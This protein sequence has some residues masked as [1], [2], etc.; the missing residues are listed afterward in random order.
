MNSA[1]VGKAVDAYPLKKTPEIES[2]I[3]KLMK[4]DTGGDPTTG[5]KW[6]RKTRQKMVD[7]LR[8]S[9][10]IVIGKTKLGEFLH[11]L[12]YSLKG[13]RKNLSMGS[14]PDRNQQFQMIAKRRGEFEAAGNPIISVDAKKR[15]LVGRFYNRGAA[16]RKEP[17]NVN[18]H[19]FPSCA[20]GVAI[21]FGIFDL[22][23]YAGFV[24]V[25]TSFNTPEFAVNSIVRWWEAEGQRQYPHQKK[26]LILADS[27]GC[28]GCRPR[29]WK[30]NLQKK[31]CDVYGLTTVV[32]HYPTGAS[33]WNPIEH[34]LFGE[35]S[36]HWSGEVLDS[37]DKILECISDTR[38]TTG[39]RVQ[40]H[41]DS[42][43]YKK[44]VKVNRKEMN[45]L[46]LVPAKTLGQ[47]NYTIRP[48]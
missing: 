18:D 13:L 15:E 1:S 24:Y 31:L 4:D 23:A 45:T 30:A 20:D 44:G 14:H 17:V 10:G 46:S 42:T 33:K 39:L 29:A 37:Y 12:D 36:K 11:N 38:T 41:L 3:E 6:T 25:G 2:Q 9:L 35:I 21:P 27:G 47:W 19:D 7:M 28:N 48:R 40:A 32:C 22:L 26:I 8:A 5:R 16:W 34:R 43:D